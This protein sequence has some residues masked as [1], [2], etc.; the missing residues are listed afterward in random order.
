MEEGYMDHRKYHSGHII[1]NIIEEPVKLIPIGHHELN[2]HLVYRI[3]GEDGS[4]EIL[5][6][7]YV[8]NRWNREVA[9]LK[10]L[11][12]S[13]VKTPKLISHGILQNGTEWLITECIEGVPLNTV[14]DK[15]SIDNQKKIYRDMGRELGK[16]HRYHTF[17]FFG[18]W[19]EN[20]NSLDYNMDF[21]TVFMRRVNTIFEQLFKQLLPEEP[22]QRKAARLLI[23][24][25]PLIENVSESHLCHNDYNIRNVM[26]KKIN[27]EWRLEGI[28]DFEQSFPWDKDIDL[29]YL[30]H[31]L[32][33]KEM[34]LK[35]EFIKGYE[36]FC[37]IGD[38]FY[39]KMNFYLLYMGLYI[40]SWSCKPAPAY[41]RHG[42]ELLSSLVNLKD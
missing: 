19:D 8:K 39:K 21:R 5:K 35:D 34:T 15:I 24:N 18:N 17:N 32:S 12:D 3:E 33:K 11:S 10:C 23:N 20:G 16:I 41:Y 37:S 13:K 9:T 22:L 26:V 40:C 30:F 28:I 14:I 29:V 36:E 6:L 27:D 4:S 42:I 2:R 38:D 7:F 25:F 1:K 31:S